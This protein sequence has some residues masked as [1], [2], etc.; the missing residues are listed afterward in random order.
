MQL[1]CVEVIMYIQILMKTFNLI[2]IPSNFMLL[3]S[4]ETASAE[5][6]ISTLDEPKPEL[7]NN[8]KEH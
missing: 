3:F 6:V 8:V 1:L 2:T 7:E 4:D 5:D